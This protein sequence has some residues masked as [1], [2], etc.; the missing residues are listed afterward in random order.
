LQKP[1][2][3]ALHAERTPVV[4]SAAA[5][6]HIKSWPGAVSDLIA[7]GWR[8]SVVVLMRSLS[9]NRWPLLRNAL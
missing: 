5:K 4:A 6:L 9:T 7:S 1:P 3:L 8:L 2:V